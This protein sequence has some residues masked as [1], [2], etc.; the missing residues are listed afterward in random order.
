ML[1]LNNW[2]FIPTL[3][4]SNTLKIYENPNENKVT[5]YDDGFIQVIRILNL[6]KRISKYVFIKWNKI[7]SEYDEIWKIERFNDIFIFKWRKW[8]KRMYINISNWKNIWWEFDKISSVYKDEITWEFYF[9]ALLKDKKM[10]IN[11]INWKNTT[12]TFKDKLLSILN[13][14]IL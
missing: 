10:K 11:I 4:T 12:R 6:S 5:L 3:K 9:I 2:S 14:K 7:I 13:F 8:N 1:G